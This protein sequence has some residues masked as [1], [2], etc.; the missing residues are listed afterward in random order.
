M[1]VVV[2]VCVW[3]REYSISVGDKTTKHTQ[4]YTRSN[5]ADKILLNKNKKKIKYNY[6]YYEVHALVS[7]TLFHTYTHKNS[8]TLNTYSYRE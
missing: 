2:V 4:S 3:E 5:R 7:F 6:N 8:F 1:F